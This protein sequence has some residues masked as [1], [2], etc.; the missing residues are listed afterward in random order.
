MKQEIEQTEEEIDKLVVKLTS[1]QNKLKFYEAIPPPPVGTKFK[2]TKDANN[3]R[4]AI[5][6]KK[7]FLEVK[8][9]TNGV[10][11]YHEDGCK[12]VP[13]EEIRLSN[14]HIPPWRKG[15]PL[16]LTLFENEFHWRESFDEKGGKMVITSAPL[17]KEIRALRA[18]P[19]KSKTDAQKLKELE[20]RFP[21]AI[22]TLIV[23]QP[24][25]KQYDIKYEGDGISCKEG[26]KWS[27]FFSAFGNN[28]EMLVS[29]RGY[30]FDVNHLL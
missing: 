20:K 27:L 11:S 15:P 3:Y 8:V 10:A 29:W 16:L 30:I 1:L 26:D 9:V 5:Q 22:I 6:T 18:T 2:W 7:G 23:T 17:P 14:G 19:L 4:V 13:C 28:Y 21:E 24:Q 25:H 12:C